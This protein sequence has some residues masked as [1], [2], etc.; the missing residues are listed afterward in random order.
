MTNNKS[1]IYRKGEK[2]DLKGV[3]ALI[4]E[5]AKFEKAPQEVT[6]TLA[7]LEEDGFGEKPIFGFFVAKEG[8]EILGFAL[9]YEKYSTWKGRCLYLEDFYV[10]ENHR[11]KGIGERLFNMVKEEARLRGSKR[12]EWQV[13]DWNEVGLSFY[14]KNGADLDGEWIIGKYRYEQ[15]QKQAWV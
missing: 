10:Q 11:R 1:L 12:M 15:L 13:L 6:L 9:Y 8:E 5:L 3:L 7:D 2:N 4:H 14:E